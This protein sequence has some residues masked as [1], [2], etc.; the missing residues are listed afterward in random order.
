MVR[1]VIAADISGNLGTIRPDSNRAIA[2]AR[3]LQ[4]ILPLR[5]RMGAG[6][7]H[8]AARAAGLRL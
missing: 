8:A 7:L 1:R 4:N 6:A 2:H 3:K 5:I